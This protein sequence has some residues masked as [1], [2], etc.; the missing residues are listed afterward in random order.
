[1]NTEEDE[2]DFE[3][4]QIGVED[5]IDLVT[6]YDDLELDT[7]PWLTTMLDK[8]Y[9]IHG[10]SIDSQTGALDRGVSDIRRMCEVNGLDMYNPYTARAM[11]LG[12]MFATNFVINAGPS[13]YETVHASAEL[14][15]LCHALRDKA[16]A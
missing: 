3:G 1:M 2:D 12:L 6:Y 7:A 8:V 11:S 16:Q 15:I 10:E 4:E 9:E 14:R 13:T 5:M